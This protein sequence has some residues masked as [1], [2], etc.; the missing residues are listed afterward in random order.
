[1]THLHSD[2]MKRDLYQEFRKYN[3]DIFEFLGQRLYE[4]IL[5]GRLVMEYTVSTVTTESIS[6]YL[7]ESGVPSTLTEYAFSIVTY[8]SKCA[9]LLRYAGESR[10][11]ASLSF[12]N[13]LFEFTKLFIFSRV[14][15]KV[16]T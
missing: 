8:A 9:L 7:L 3:H 12:Q 15:V 11:L 16:I 10:D 14:Q 5:T 13:I 6:L 4:S 1:M 2:S